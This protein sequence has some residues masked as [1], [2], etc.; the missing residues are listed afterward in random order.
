MLTSEEESTILSHTDGCRPIL[1]QALVYG[2]LLWNGIIYT[3]ASYRPD[4][5][6]DDAILYFRDNLIGE[7][8]KFVSYCNSNCTCSHTGTIKCHHVVLVRQLQTVP[9]IVTYIKIVTSTQRYNYN[10]LINSQ[11]IGIH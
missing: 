6:K 7:A 2:R 5:A 9:T 10:S 11:L 1:S 8:V 4:A 3:N